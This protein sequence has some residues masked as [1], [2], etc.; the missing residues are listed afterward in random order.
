MKKILKFKI[1]NDFP[2]PSQTHPKTTRRSS[3]SLEPTFIQPAATE[4]ERME[5]REEDIVE[6]IVNKCIRQAEW[7]FVQPNDQLRRNIMTPHIRRFIRKIRRVNG[8]LFFHTSNGA[9][10]SLSAVI[11]PGT[12][13]L[14]GRPSL[15]LNVITP[16]VLSRL[17]CF[18]KVYSS[19]IEANR[20][21]NEALLLFIITSDP[22][23]RLTSA[24]WSHILPAL[25]K[26]QNVCAAITDT[27]TLEFLT[28]SFLF[29]KT[30]AVHDNTLNFPIYFLRKTKDF[31]MPRPNTPSPLVPASRKIS[32]IVKPI[33]LTDRSYSCR[34]PAVRLAFTKLP[35]GQAVKKAKKRNKGTKRIISL[36]FE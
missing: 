30:T 4:M 15:D 31:I 36:G 13:F 12:T 6:F 23:V 29:E 18:S 35:L 17:I 10:K 8:E 19:V 33:Q 1:H 24:E 5:P 34:Q 22:I 7:E 25:V 21:S 16:G 11:P 26:Y 9:I 20:N 2:V 27:F 28:N 32:G 14:P 3:L